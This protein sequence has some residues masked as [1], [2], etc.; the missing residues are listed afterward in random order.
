MVIE[1]LQND[2][3]TMSYN[4]GYNVSYDGYHYDTGCIDFPK[5]K[6]KK[7]YNKRIEENRYFA[8]VKDNDI[9]EYVGYVNYHYNKSNSRYECGVVIEAKHRGKGYAKE[10]LKLLCL[11]AFNNGV[12]KLYDSFEKDR[13]SALKIFLSVGFKIEKEVT[14]KKFGKTVEGVIV[15]LEKKFF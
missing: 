15:S 5:E 2:A 14:W 6:W 7:S 9:E 13:I 8:Y 11:E 1:K 3:S 12:D 4:A 10:A